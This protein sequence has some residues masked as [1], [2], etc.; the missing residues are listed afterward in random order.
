MIEFG[1]KNIHTDEESIMFGYNIADAYKRA[2]L[3]MY[4]W[5]ITYC[6]YID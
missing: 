4:T 2:R 6:D 3:D 5:H 1:I